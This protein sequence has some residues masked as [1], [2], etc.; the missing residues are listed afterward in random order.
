[1]LMFI[2]LLL[3]LF[4]VYYLSLLQLPLEEAMLACSDLIT[5]QWKNLFISDR[6][7]ITLGTLEVLIKVK[8]GTNKR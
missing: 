5:S 1:M 3:L 8:V 4:V 7:I 2:I 6:K